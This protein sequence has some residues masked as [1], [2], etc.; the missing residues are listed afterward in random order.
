MQLFIVSPPIIYLLWRYKH[1]FA[2]V[3]AAL[4]VAVAGLTVYLFVSYGFS[5]KWLDLEL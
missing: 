5:G 3:L 1:K 4:I 2:P